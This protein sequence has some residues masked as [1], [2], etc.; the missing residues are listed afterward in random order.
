MLRF[1]VR[2]CLVL[3]PLFIGVTILSFYIANLSPGDPVAMY[4]DPYEKPDPEKVEAIRRELGLDKPVITRYFLW[5]AKVLQGDLGYSLS[6]KRPVL[7]EIRARIGPSLLLSGTSLCIS[8]VLGI[9][10]GVYS[11]MNQY[12]ASD[13]VLTVLSFIGISMPTFWFA[14]LLIILLTGTLG[15][16]PSVGMVSFNTPPGT[17]N[18]IVDVARHLVMPVTVTTLGSIAGWARMERSTMLEV[19][20]QD[21]IRTAR[22]KGIRERFVIFR[23]AV[24]NAALPIITSLGMSLPGLIGGSF[25]IE[26]IFGWPG[27]GRLGTQAIFSRD[28]PIIM[29]VNIISSL[30]I[31]LGNLAADVTYALVDPR[32]RYGGGAE[33]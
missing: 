31:M 32:I 27:M 25:V 17:W 12:K 10:L 20:R 19:L 22:A 6:S 9:S 28:Y 30:L 15:W 7:A 4:L 8:F 3:I 2:R 16:L 1:I 33:K 26:S 13:Y 18:H 5:L 24:R 11:A 14:M 21:Y 23:H 29:G